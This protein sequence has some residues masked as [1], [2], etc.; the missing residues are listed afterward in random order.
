MF[1]FSAVKNYIFRTNLFASL[2]LFMSRYINK[3][4]KVF[5]TIICSNTINMM[6]TFFSSKLPTYLFFYYQ[7]MLEFIFSFTTWIK[8]ILLNISLSCFIYST[9]PPIVFISGYL[10][11]LFI[12]IP[13]L[14]MKFLTSVPRYIF[15]FKSTFRNKSEFF[16]FVPRYTIFLKCHLITSKIKAAF[17]GLK[18]TVK[19]PHLLTAILDTKNPFPSSKYSI[20]DNFK[21]VKTNKMSCLY[22]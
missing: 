14:I 4:H 21:F 20:V 18:E 3:G 1:K 15:L 6:D 9:F 12:F 5:R 22:I 10:S 13:N 17:G 7:T 19:F 2:K 16:S 8:N 11:I